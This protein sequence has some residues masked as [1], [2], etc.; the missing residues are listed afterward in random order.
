MAKISTLLQDQNHIFHICHICHFGHIFQAGIFRQIPLENTGGGICHSTLTTS[1]Q[2]Q[3][4]TNLSSDQLSSGQPNAQRQT[5]RPSTNTK[6]TNDKHTSNRQSEGSNDAVK[7]HNLEFLRRV[8]T[9]SLKR[10]QRAHAHL[11]LAP[12]PQSIL[13]SFQSSLTSNQKV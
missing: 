9:W 7:I 2:P 1:A 3:N 10:L 11:T 12:F 8:M 5:N 6:P 13:H 4:R